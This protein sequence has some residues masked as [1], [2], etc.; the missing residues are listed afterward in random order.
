MILRCAC[1]AVAVLA[2]GLSWAGDWPGFRGPDR[3][4]CTSETGL[5]WQWDEHRLPVLWKAS[6]GKGFSSFAVAEGRA[7]TMGNE[8]GT[9][10]VWCFDAEKGV[11]LWKHSYL[12][13]LQPL[14]YEGGP[15]STPMIANGRV[16]TFSKGGDLF[17]LDLQKGSV[18]WSNKFAPWPW[19][20]GDWKNTWRY[21]GS[22][23]V[24]GDTLF[25]SLGQA[26]AALNAKDGAVL[27]KS[28]DGHPGYSSPVP[29]R[30]GTKA[31][32]AFFSGRS[33]IGVEA[34]TGKRLWEIPWKTEWDFNAADPVVHEG[35][36]FVSSGNN[37][38]GALF[39]VSGTA[40]R[41]M[42][43]NK[44]LK[45]PMNGA[46][47]WQ[48]YLYGFNDAE[49]VCVSWKTGELKWSERGLRRGSLALAEGLLLALS[50]NG[51]WA[52]AP[53]SPAGFKPLS[54]VPVMTGRCWTSPALSRGLLYL[55]NAQGDV[56]CLD[57]RKR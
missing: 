41:E 8:G 13:E 38:G 35:Q 16:F 30:L 39:D 17:C 55:R 43:R 42:W 46:I 31:A 28:E 53:A 6:V 37:A 20:E 33:V 54:Q 19:R 14:S 25:L 27:W 47:L 45:T 44:N 57:A 9:D 32:L 26:G 12:C 48:G 51:K 29:F 7:V 4:G 22:P 3:T 2:A 40:P 10:T 49:L 1:W 5:N 15:G 52:V 11:V 34:Q 24:V 36:L 21:A 56:V 18:I 23:L 50:E